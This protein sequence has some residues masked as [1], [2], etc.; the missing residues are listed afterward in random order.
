MITRKLFK[1]LGILPSV[2]L[3]FGCDQISKELVRSNV[4]PGDYI[5]V[6]ENHLILTNVEN[7]GA[8]LG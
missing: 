3:N 8:M 1:A 4:K 2:I 5:E 6:V 7:T